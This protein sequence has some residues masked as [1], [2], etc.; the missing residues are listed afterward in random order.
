MRGKVEIGI[1]EENVMDM[2]KDKVAII[3][4]AAK[5]NGAGIAEVMA[6]EGALV[7]LWDIVDEVG[8]TAKEIS[9]SG[10]KAAAFNVDVIDFGQVNRATKAVIKRFGRVDI[11]VNNAGIYPLVPF[12]EVSDELRDKCWDVNLKGT[13]NCT[14]A[15]LPFMIEQ[16]SGKIVNI[17]SVTGPL[18]SAPGFTPYAMSKGAISAMTKSL[19][20]EVAPYG[21][22]VNAILPGSIDTPGLRALAVKR[23]N[24]PDQAM[25]DAGKTIP[26]GRL[27]S[28]YDIGAA[29]VF[30]ASEY[31]NYITGAEL[32]VDGGNVIQ[33]LKRS[34]Q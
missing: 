12:L 2:L 13:W 16:K 15:V 14:K 25:I 18:V 34:R 4:G 10:Q 20:L 6:R 7:C 24:D 8:E 31:A 33:E 30:L 21:I 9:E 19:A 5:G 22:N 11:L 26:L 28:C 32:V 17:S 29:A 3:T 23:G 1:G 27:G